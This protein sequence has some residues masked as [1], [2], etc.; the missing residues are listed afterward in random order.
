MNLSQIALLFEIFGFLMASFFL[1]VF[2]VDR[3]RSFFDRRKA[4]IIELDQAISN[5]RKS[6][7]E[8]GIRIL[9]LTLR[10]LKN[11]M[12][13]VKIIVRIVVFMVRRCELPDK[14]IREGMFKV[15]V[16]GIQILTMLLPILLSWP[17]LLVIE[18][19]AKSLAGKEAVTILFVIG[20]TLLVFTGLILE[21]IATL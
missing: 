8:K 14:E 1:A 2:R 4:S 5:I 12:R 3:I 13:V 18:F 20:G 15:I 6:M 10:S 11:Q 19:A 7:S 16:L 17:F 9:P 21:L